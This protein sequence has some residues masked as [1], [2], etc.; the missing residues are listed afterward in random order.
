MLEK[1]EL[2]DFKEGVAYFKNGEYSKAKEYFKE[3]LQE[4]PWHVNGWSALALVHFNEGNFAE[5]VRVFDKA[6]G[7]YARLKCPSVTGKPF[8][9][10][11][12]ELVRFCKESRDAFLAQAYTMKAQALINM[13]R[14]D[15]AEKCVDLALSIDPWH[16]YALAW[17]ADLLIHRGKEEEG[18]KSARMALKYDPKNTIALFYKG[19]V[20]LDMRKPGEALPCFERLVE[21]DP[22]E[23]NGW[24][25][26]G[27]CCYELRKGG[28]A[29]KYVSRVV[30]MCPTHKDG[31]YLKS[32]VHKALGQKDEFEKCL[33]R[34]S[35]VPVDAPHGKATIATIDRGNKQTIH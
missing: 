13:N 10:Q 14:D 34:Y 24:F 29:L 23:V 22:D 19:K 31:W 21:L 26:L 25:Y 12:R 9:E 17:K 20:L 32:L 15:D 1:N 5:S 33:Y 27:A 8:E 35:Q 11:E 6:I 2:A 16:S 30:E 18:L 7:F 4:N 3:R 28:E